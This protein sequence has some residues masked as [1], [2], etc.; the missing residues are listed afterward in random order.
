MQNSCYP[1]GG[2]GLVLYCISRGMLPGKIGG[3]SPTTPK[4]TMTVDSSDAKLG[5][6]L[7][8]MLSR[9]NVNL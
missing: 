2:L 1:I 3:L 5:M 8:E 9:S 4:I 6:V 7:R